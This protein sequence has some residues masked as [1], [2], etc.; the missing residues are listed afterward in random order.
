MFSTE[1]N[2]EMHGLGLKCA[3]HCLYSCRSITAQKKY[4]TDHILSYKTIDVLSIHPL[5]TTEVSSHAWF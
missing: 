2:N 3:P 4:R 5:K 1:S